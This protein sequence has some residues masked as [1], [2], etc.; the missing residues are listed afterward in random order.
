MAWEAFCEF[1]GYARW[2]EVTI[3]HNLH[4]ECP[5]VGPHCIH[6]CWLYNRDGSELRVPEAGDSAKRNE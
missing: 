3:W 2:S 6:C 5:I 1:C 4:D